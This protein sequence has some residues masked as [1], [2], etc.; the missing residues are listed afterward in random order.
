MKRASL[1][2]FE[3]VVLLTVAVLEVQ[4]QAYG[5]AI[6]HEIIEET[7]RS[8]RL[9]QIHAAL[10]RLEDKGMVKSEMGEPTAERG[11]RRKRLFTVTA[12]GRR[13]LQ[14]IQDV[15]A[16]LWTRLVSPFKLSTSL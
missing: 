2:E 10:Q 14:E 3:E 11:G 15:R 16:S 8:V 4:G 13:T 1:G 9:N 6:T 7:G 12:Y 5:V